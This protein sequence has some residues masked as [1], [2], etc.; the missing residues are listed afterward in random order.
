MRLLRSEK[1]EDMD[2]TLKAGE[3]ENETILQ[4]EENKEMFKIDYYEHSMHTRSRTM[5]TEM[6]VPAKQA[7]KNQLTFTMW[8]RHR[9]NKEDIMR[10]SEK[11]RSQSSFHSGMN[12]QGPELANER[13]QYKLRKDKPYLNFGS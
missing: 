13:V 7:G 2:I 10:Q 1:K 9:E 12:R 5:V 4:P 8:K 3:A 6:P 11:S